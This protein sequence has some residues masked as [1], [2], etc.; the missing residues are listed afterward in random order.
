MWDVFRCKSIANKRSNK[1][2]IFNRLSYVG[3]VGRELL[4]TTEQILCTKANGSLK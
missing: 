2:F 1:Y 3:P 4:L